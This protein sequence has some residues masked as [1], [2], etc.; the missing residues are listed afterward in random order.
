MSLPPSS[1]PSPL[2]PSTDPKP[3]GP[4]HQDLA[5]RRQ[6][7]KTLRKV[8]FYKMAWRAFIM[9]GLA[10]G[11]VKLATSPI[12][13]IRSIEQISVDVKDNARL[14][15][16]NIQALLSV[17]YP[18]S[19]LSVQPDELA[20]G[21]MAHS[22]IEKAAISRRLVPP[23]LKVTVSER[24]P[25]AVTLPNIEKPLQEIPDEPVPFEEP[26]MIDAEG[27]WMPRNSF[28]ELGAIA[29][30]PALTIKGMQ[31]SQTDSWR[32][33]YQELARTPI[34]ITQVD[35]TRPSNLILQ[36][37]LGTVHIGPYSKAFAAQLAAL[38]QMRL[39]KDK[40]DPEKVAF[41]DI[42]NP[43]KPV[44]EVLQAT[45]NPLETP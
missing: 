20:D 22:P 29:P 38:D 11:T 13:L 40:V 42:K 32:S 35:W 3:L 21:L 5:Y 36:T 10:I 28:T 18:Q 1:P 34:V 45:S 15:E 17:P 30:P 31:K 23:G 41:I 33:L 9:T 7:L 14:S 27:Y 44:I 43:E 8:K 19:L 6:Q 2:P 12:W 25:V 37:E 24:Q 39:V 26:G 4:S 16:E